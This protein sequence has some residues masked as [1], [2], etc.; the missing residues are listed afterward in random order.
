M[1]GQGQFFTFSE[2]GNTKRTLGNVINNITPTDIPCI[3][4]FGLANQGK[5]R[6][7]NFP[8]HKYEWLEDTLRVRT[9][10]VNGT[11][12]GTTTAL[13]VSSGH[14]IRFKPGDVWITAGG[15]LFWVDAVSTDTLTVIPNWGA[16]AGGSQGTWAA[17]VTTATTLT[18]K[19][20]ARLEGDDSDAQYWTSLTNPYNYSQIMHGEVKVSDSEIRATSRYGVSDQFAYQLGKL[21]G[22]AGA[23]A[24]KQGRAGDLMI[25]LENTFFSGTR[26][27]RSATAAGGM[28]GFPYFVTTNVSSN[29]G[30]ARYL[31]RTILENSLQTIWEAGGM[32]DVIICNA[33]QKRMISSFYE[34]SV[35]TERSERT[36][37]VVINTIETEFGNYDLMLNRRADTGKVFIAQRDKVG[38][39]TLRPWFVKPLAEDG[40]YTKK[41][42]VGEYGFV[43]ENETAH[44]IIKDLS[45]S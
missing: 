12:S 28:G 24:G 27:Q 38:W 20:S 35:R 36:G 45:A 26:I 10:T 2:T 3:S 39:V 41:E 34:G 29:S 15:D 14:G 32:P 43:V 17:T 11:I 6:L 23:G 37:G 44:G 13:V 18:Y 25:D 19:Y 7:E 1:A 40:D 22:G 8:N 21:L 4:Y 31:T 5:F 42:V 30:T 33:F 16:Y 9:A